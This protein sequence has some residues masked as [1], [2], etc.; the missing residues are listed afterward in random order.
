MQPNTY[1]YA[2]SRLKN[3][4]DLAKLFIEKGGSFNLLNKNV[5]NNKS[6]AML[7]VQIN[8]KNYQHLNKKLK[9][10]DEIFE[11]VVELDKRMIG[12][13]SERLRAIYRV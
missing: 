10:D 5:R 3:N 4:I 8:P 11:I 2:S 6:V 7:S 13:A 9:D 12:C 1:K